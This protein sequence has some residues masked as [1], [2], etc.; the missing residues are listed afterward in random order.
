MRKT[1]PIIMTGLHAS[2]RNK[3]GISIFVKNAIRPFSL[4][5]YKKFQYA[6]NKKFNESL[7]KGKPA[8]D[9]YSVNMFTQAL[10]ICNIQGEFTTLPFYHHKRL[11]LSTTI[12]RD[13]R[14]SLFFNHKGH[15]GYAKEYKE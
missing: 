4:I 9:K 6:P 13:L 12:L 10:K 8:K 1:S 11:H 2:F 5:Y 7:K 3:S 15:K 14:G